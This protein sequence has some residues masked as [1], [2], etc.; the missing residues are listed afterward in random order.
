MP[1]INLT[2]RGKRTSRTSLPSM[3]SIGRPGRETLAGSPQAV[4]GVVA[5]AVLVAAVFLYFGETRSLSE[6]EAAIVEAE[7][8]ST[9]LHDR[10]QRVQRL[11]ET[12][13]RLATRV[14]MME[15]VVEGRARSIELWET[16]SDALPGST[17]LNR[18]DRE[19]LELDRIRIEGATFQNAAITDYMRALEASDAFERITLI[20]VSRVL[21]N[22]GDRE[23]SF[24]SFTVVAG[25]E[26]YTPVRIAPADTTDTTEDSP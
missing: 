2:P 22:Q 15:Q 19:D 17:W 12:Q 3:P 18:V 8:D 11:E 16:L 7:R 6:V 14:A 5:F 9:E 25:Y 10:I 1:R 23:V 24:Q 26:D 13:E 4:V 20:G 21:E